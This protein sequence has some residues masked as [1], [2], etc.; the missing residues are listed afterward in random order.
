MSEVV[1]GGISYI[2]PGGFIV[3]QLQ[4]QLDR[5]GLCFRNWHRVVEV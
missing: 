2:Q 1:Y 3:R 4:L 5:L